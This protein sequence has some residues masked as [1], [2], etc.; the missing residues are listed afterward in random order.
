MCCVNLWCTFGKARVVLHG[1][2][3]FD[4]FCAS[5][6]EKYHAFS[7]SFHLHIK[8]TSL[9]KKSDI[10]LS[11]VIIRNNKDMEKKRTNTTDVTEDVQ[12]DVTEDETASVTENVTTPVCCDTVAFRYESDKYD[13]VEKPSVTTGVTGYATEYVTANVTSHLTA[14]VTTFVTRKE[15]TKLKRSSCDLAEVI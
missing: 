7:I 8:M 11:F 15:E 6:K 3:V 5:M 13:N 9:M 2:G 10:Y 12:V 14:N 4:P 1:D